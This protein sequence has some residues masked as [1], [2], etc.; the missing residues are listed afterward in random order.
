M[1]GGQAKNRALMQLMADVCGME[2]V[3]PPGDGSVV[4]P[5]VLG[6]AMLGRYAG[7]ARQG[8]GKEGQAERLW[9]IMVRLS[10]FLFSLFNPLYFFFQGRNDAHRHSHLSKGV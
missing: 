8:G 2:V 5:V 1:S 7:E 9:G 10:C 6:A 3:V 4:D